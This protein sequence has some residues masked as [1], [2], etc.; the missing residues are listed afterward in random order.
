ME[1]QIANLK[2][3]QKGVIVSTVAYI[4][5][6]VIKLTVGIISGSQALVADGLHNLT[7]IL[8]SIAIIIGIRISM[9]PKD[10]GHPY[11][12]LR[13]ETV[14]SQIVSILMIIIGVKVMF[15]AAR[16]ITS[17]KDSPEIIAAVVALLCSVMMFFVYRYSSNLAKKTNSAGLLTA[18]KDNLADSIVGLGAAIGIFASQFGLPW[19]DPIVAVIVGIIIIKTGWEIFYESTYSLMDG[20]DKN[21]LD[22][23]SEIISSVPGVKDVSG[24][25][26]RKTGN[27][28]I[29][30]VEIHVDPHLTVVEGHDIADL[31]QQRVRDD[32]EFCEAIVHVEPYLEE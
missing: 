23:I 31:V 2:R 16:S 5:Q 3:A 6:T 13:A 4:I 15:E 18:A 17:S 9:K 10:D 29:I 20:M 12:H 1:K 22:E 26:G 8:S 30:D 25:R 32:I 14:A 11:G 21:K 27:K 24:P 7:D 19:I 28:L